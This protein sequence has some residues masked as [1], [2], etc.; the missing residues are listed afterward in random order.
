MRTL[1]TVAQQNEFIKQNGRVVN[2]EHYYSNRG[3]GTSKIFNSRKD[4]ISKASGCG[5]DRFG[6]VIGL[7]IEEVFNK[8]LQKLG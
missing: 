8:E 2:V 1:L 5:Y 4:V 6:T 7:Y 3:L